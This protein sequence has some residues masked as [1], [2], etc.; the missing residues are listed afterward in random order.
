MAI[1]GLGNAFIPESLVRYGSSC[2]HPTYYQIDQFF[3]SRDLYIAY[4]K[5]RYYSKAI[6]E[7][8]NTVRDVLQAPANQ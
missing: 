1:C 4:R 8:I 3:P 6:S 7:F 2:K 5:D